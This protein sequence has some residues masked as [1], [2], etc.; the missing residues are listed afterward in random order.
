MR[1]FQSTRAK[2]SETH[3]GVG[4]HMADASFWN[5]S[6]CWGTAWNKCMDSCETALEEGSSAPEGFKMGLRV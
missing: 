3:L 6:Q 2:P 1:A 4:T 5:V